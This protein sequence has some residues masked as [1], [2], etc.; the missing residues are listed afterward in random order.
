MIETK[1]DYHLF[2]WGQ[3][4]LRAD[5]NI[6]SLRSFFF[7]FNKK[8]CLQNMKDGGVGNSLRAGV[9]AGGGGAGYCQIWAI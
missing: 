1:V 3:C 8:Y 5:E 9:G 6:I 4:L 2:Q 7:F